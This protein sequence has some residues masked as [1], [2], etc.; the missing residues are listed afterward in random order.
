MRNNK[1]FFIWMFLIGFSFFIGACEKTIPSVPGHTFDLPQGFFLVAPHANPAWDKAGAYMPPCSG[2]RGNYCYVTVKAVRYV[3][4]DDKNPKLL[5]IG[6][7][8]LGRY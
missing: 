1:A 8:S 5:A 3:S 2:G 7:L 4:P 6:E